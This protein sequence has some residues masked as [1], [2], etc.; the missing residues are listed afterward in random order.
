MSAP[1]KS[2]EELAR[3]FLPNIAGETAGWCCGA[4]RHSS[5]KGCCSIGHEMFLERA[6]KAICERDKQIRAAA[7]A[8]AFEEASKL[9]GLITTPTDA[10]RNILG[11]VIEL[12]LDQAEE[13]RSK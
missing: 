13:E 3:D 11:E 8:E 2:A 12:L 10:G 9:V 6:A 4:A 1:I 7:R 5:S